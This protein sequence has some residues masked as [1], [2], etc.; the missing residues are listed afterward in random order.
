MAHFFEIDPGT[1][2]EFIA[3]NN[4][5][6][7]EEREGRLTAVIE[8]GEKFRLGWEFEWYDED[9]PRPHGAGPAL[10]EGRYAILEPISGYDFQIQKPRTSKTGPKSWAH[11]KYRWDGAFTE[12]SFGDTSIEVEQA[13]FYLV[14]LVFGLDN[15]SPY[16]NQLYPEERFTDFE[17]RDVYG[18]TTDD[19]FATHGFKDFIVEVFVDDYWTVRLDVKRDFI[20]W[21]E[22]PSGFYVTA[23][24]RVS[25]PRTPTRDD[26]RT[27]SFEKMRERVESLALLLSLANGGMTSAPYIEGCFAEIEGNKLCDEGYAGQVLLAPTTPLQDIGMGIFSWTGHDLGRLIATLPAFEQMLV[28]WGE[29]FRLVL[30][31]YHKALSPYAPFQSRVRSIS[32]ALETVAMLLFRR[33][34]DGKHSK[35]QLNKL[36]SLS[37][38]LEALAWVAGIPSDS[39]DVSLDIV[40]D[41]RHESAHAEL[42]VDSSLRDGA[43]RTA[44]TL[45]EEIML[46][47][48]GY[49]GKYCPKT[50]A[51]DSSF[52][53]PRYK[54]QNRLPQW[55]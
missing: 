50:D 44:V 7:Q 2:S 20:H 40:K 19:G 10:H 29:Y 8:L 6:S 43:F 11:R 46:W 23:K 22:A 24:G 42:S 55:V 9:A 25:G 31:D 17:H 1:Q 4:I 35:T 39:Y 3:Y 27:L 54:L 47:R 15:D 34:F 49:T 41:L 37:T 51:S 38:K 18:V 36:F 14:N 53:E 28:T 16:Q 21:D 32:S 45:F 30:A 5:A 33:E 26:V 52:G 13:S 48:L 12:G